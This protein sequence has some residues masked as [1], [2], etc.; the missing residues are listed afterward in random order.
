[1]VKDF[2]VARDSCAVLYDMIGKG[3]IDGSRVSAEVNVDWI[4]E[5]RL[6]YFDSCYL[7]CVCFFR[8]AFVARFD[9]C[10]VFWTVDESDR[11]KV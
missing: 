7:V 2:I 8:R 10:L 6:C 5:F 1:M 9:C 3:L 4:C 11:I